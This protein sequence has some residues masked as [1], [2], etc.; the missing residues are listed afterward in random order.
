MRF[1]V[2]ETV[3]VTLRR[4]WGPYPEGAEIEVDTVKAGTLDEQGYLSDP[5]EK[6][7]ARKRG[8]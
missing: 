2:T 1:P 8:R 6:R 5:D 7:P 4:P 3:K